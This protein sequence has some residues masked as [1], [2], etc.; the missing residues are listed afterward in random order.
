MPE[1][2]PK[3]QHTGSD[4]IFLVSRPALNRGTVGIHITR[5]FSRQHQRKS[6]TTGDRIVAPLPA[7]GVRGCERDTRFGGRR[8]VLLHP[9]RRPRAVPVRQ[10]ERTHRL[11]R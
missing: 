8:R 1:L 6:T 5:V 9:R 7:G 11:W 4:F 10:T 2:H 3:G